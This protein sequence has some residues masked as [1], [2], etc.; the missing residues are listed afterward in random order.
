VRIAAESPAIV[1]RQGEHDSSSARLI[2][3]PASRKNYRRLRQVVGAEAEELR[4]LRRRGTANTCS[5][6]IQLQSGHP[7][8]HRDDLLF[9][10]HHGLPVCLRDLGAE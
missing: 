4:L 2:S 9:S 6:R 10:K 1:A 7:A 3:T 5:G 8:R